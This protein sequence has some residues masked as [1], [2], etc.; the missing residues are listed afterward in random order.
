LS[1]AGARESIKKRGFAHIWKADNAY[2]ERHSPQSVQDGFCKPKKGFRE[3]L[4]IY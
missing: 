2:L 3:S 1:S 4:T